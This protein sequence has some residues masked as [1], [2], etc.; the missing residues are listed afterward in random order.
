MLPIR[1]QAMC[2]F[3]IILSMKAGFG[4]DWLQGLLITDRMHYAT[5][6]S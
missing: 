5:P 2:V 6:L 3:V 4:A 1:V